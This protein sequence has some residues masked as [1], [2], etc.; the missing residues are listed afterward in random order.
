MVGGIDWTGA[1][2]HSECFSNSVFFMAG[3][4][5]R[6]RS[7]EALCRHLPK[8]FASR[9]EVRLVRL[10]CLLPPLR[11]QH[12]GPSD[13]PSTILAMSNL[14]VTYADMGEMKEARELQKEVLRPRNKPHT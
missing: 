7:K 11:C 3:A 6:G 9:G 2:A 5:A 1:I 13:H 12:V 10:S 8:S 14:A 4:V